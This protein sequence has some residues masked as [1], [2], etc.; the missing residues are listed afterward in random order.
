MK[1]TYKSVT[2][3]IFEVE[4]DECIGSFILESRRK[5]HADNERHRYHADFS[6]DNDDYEDHGEAAVDDDPCQRL[7]DAEESKRLYTALDK[8]TPAQ[9]RRL[10]KLAAGLT[11]A[12]IAR[13]EGA[14]F[15]SVKESIAAAQKKMKKLL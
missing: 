14:A 6:L 4:A 5:E 13:S 9:R 15:N 12:E 1:I 10:L 7:T 8:L 3:E 2:G 11:I